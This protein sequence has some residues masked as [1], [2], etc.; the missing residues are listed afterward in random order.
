MGKSKKSKKP[1]GLKI[2]RSGMKFICEWKI[3]SG[4]YDD[5]QQFKSTPGGSANV[6]KKDTKKTISIS[7]S[8]YYP[9]LNAQG[10]HKKKLT[11]F[12]FKVRGNRDAKKDNYAWSDWV[13]KSI[14]IHPPRK[15]SLSVELTGENVSKLSW[16]VADTEADKLY[17]FLRV[18]IKTKLVANCTWDPEDDS[19][20]GADS[21]TS[22]SASGSKT[23]TENSASIADGSHTRLYK[24]RAIGIAGPSDWAYAKHV[25]AAPKKSA[26]TAKENATETPGGYD[27]K[28]EWD[29]AR[30]K[31][32]PI[33]ES[34]VEWAI[35]TPNS[36]L[37]CPATGVTWN[38]GATIKDTSGA[39]AVH[40]TVDQRLDDDQ[41]LYTRINTKHDAKITYGT[42]ALRKK[43]KLAAPEGLSVEN[44][45]QENQTAKITADNESA[46]DGSI[47]AIIFRK[48]GAD[49]IV[50]IIDSSPNYRTVKCPAWA[51]TD[52][53]RFGVKAVLPKTT[54]HKTEDGITF[55]TI[56][57]YMSSDTVWQGGTVA[58]AP[59][60]I[61]LGYS[62]ENVRVTW[63]NNWGDANGT[64]LSWS[65]NPDAWESTEAPE[66]FVI[67]NPFA[68]SWLIAGLETGK[69]WYVR[70]RSLQDNGDQKTYSP[71]SDTAEINLSSSPGEPTLAISKGIVAIGEPVTL[72]WDY[73]STD[74]TPQDEAII[75]EVDENDVYTEIGRTT[76]E[77]YIDLD[78]WDEAGSVDLCVTV[79]SGSGRRSSNSGI[80]SIMVAE[81][82][83][84]TLTTS[85]VS[86]GVLDDDDTIRTIT[87]LQALP[88]DVTV[89]GA[90]TGGTTAIVVER[91]AS[92]RIDR[93]DEKDQDGYE[94][95]TIVNIIQIG[96]DPVSITAGDLIG[97][98][99]DGAQ[100]RLIATV[101][102][103]IGQTAS[104]SVDFEVDWSH[105]AGVPDAEVYI[106][107]DD[108]I[109]VIT[110]IAPQGA[111]ASDWCEIYRLSADAPELIIADGVFGTSYVDPYPAF[112][113]MSGYRIVTR[114]AES[115]YITE[116]NAIAFF[117]TNEEG[118]ELIKADRAVLDF[119]GYR[120]A[121][122][123]DIQLADK[124]KKDFTE[125]EF[126]GG[127][128]RGYWGAATNRSGSVKATALTEDRELI[129]NIR[130]LAIFGGECHVRT[131]DGSSYAA[132]IQ[133][134]KDQ[135]SP[136]AAGLTLDI[137]RVDPQSFEGMTLAEWNEGGS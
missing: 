58:T 133:V 128:V 47:I 76:T 91:A 63:T 37:S 123:M 115:S 48:N 35:A 34:V 39:E 120:V 97:S 15:P 21:D 135:S 137:T 28:V 93:P 99:D 68:T 111:A 51:D 113:E 124:W 65:D 18:E 49:S 4:G 38:T 106:N 6:G 46:V 53:V 24:V 101:I 22:S 77:E 82:A 107:E 1:S 96:E 121:L 81:P 44:V 33:D 85:L 74:G 132:D 45:D 122:S 12:S 16:S 8:D 100:Y 130:R 50:G 59:S 23:V 9:N 136:T 71:Y 69:T 17:P 67:D 87:A 70:L 43:G 116:D 112:G 129:E 64:E 109:A 75:Y 41:C 66:K 118:E 103:S 98:L 30:D 32:T 10:K 94:G 52:T 61:A 84:M 27:V 26:Q 119:D 114:T 56:D 86:E 14:T 42:A 25:Y 40:I 131:P 3:P 11:A 13:E 83:T 127:S 95:D 57:A 102:D 55:Y 29:T 79:I 90:G 73:I 19:W 89:T 31:S 105:K 80:V 108:Y 104:E 117:D 92:Y 7:A 36:D 60:D 134:S 126:L 5:G 78:G 20:N 88:F 110:P 54:T 72:S 2:T 125:K 62:G